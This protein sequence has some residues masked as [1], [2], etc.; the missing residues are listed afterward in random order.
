MIISFLGNLIIINYLSKSNY[1]QWIYILTIFFLIAAPFGSAFTASFTKIVARN[2]HAVKHD[3]ISINMQLVLLYIILI[4]VIY[5]IF[6]L[7]FSDLINLPNSLVAFFVLAS[8]TLHGW[9]QIYS[10]ILK[11]HRKVIKAQL[12]ELAIRPVVFFSFVILF[13]FYDFLQHSILSL[14]WTIA[15]LAGLIFHIWYCQISFSVVSRERFYNWWFSLKERLF[16]IIAFSKVSILTVINNQSIFLIL[17]AIG[18]SESVADIKVIFT[19]SMFVSFP[20]LIIN[21][22]VGPEIAAADGFREIKG[23]FW[24]KRKYLIALAGA[25]ILYGTILIVFGDIIVGFLY[26]Q[27]YENAYGMLKFAVFG[28]V[29]FLLTGPVGSIMLMRGFEQSLGRIFILSIFCQLILIYALVMLESFHLIFLIAC[30][31]IFLPNCFSW[32]FLLIKIK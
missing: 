18:F 4:T 13:I 21:S 11:G 10:G 8:V 22:I 30:L 16:E 17:G 3:F 20:L 5:F 19:L 26:G 14:V 12:Y 2:E 7:I 25:G 23:F 31:G 27:A 29:I 6:K 24:E 9:N 32:I 1:G 28:H 15:C